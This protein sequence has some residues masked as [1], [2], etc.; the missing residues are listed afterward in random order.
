MA[1]IQ[2]GNSTQKLSPVCQNGQ[3]IRQ[4]VWNDWRATCVD[5]RPDEEPYRHCRKLDKH[6]MRINS[7][8]GSIFSI[9][10]LKR[11]TQTNAQSKVRPHRCHFD[12]LDT[13]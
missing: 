11:F 12:I 2:R 4:I 5:E 9:Q 3:S 6:I 1:T 10:M 7:W 8:T 13:G